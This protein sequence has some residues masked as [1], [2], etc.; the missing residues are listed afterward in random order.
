MVSAPKRWLVAS[1]IAAML[2]V[3][4]MGCADD[5]M[6]G[7]IRMFAG[8]FEPRGWA[9]CDGRLL[10]ISE[11]DTLF[12]LIGTTYGG[13]GQTTFALPDLRGRFPIGEGQGPG[14]STNINAGELSGQTTKTLMM[15]EMPA[16]T[17]TM[18]G[19]VTSTLQSTAHTHSVAVPNP[20][21]ATH[22]HTVNV[23]VPGLGAGSTGAVSASA[24]STAAK[25]GVSK[26]VRATLASCTTSLSMPS[27]TG[28]QQVDVS[29]T[30]ESV[31]SYQVTTSDAGGGT[32]TITKTGHNHGGASTSTGGGQAFEIRSPSL[33]INYI[34]SLYGVFPTYS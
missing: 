17:H 5:P 24:C 19:T 27:A 12:V 10:A 32:A 8:N 23:P 4:S 29:S 9:F 16:H 6:I 26:K 25:D 30:S 28:S 1:L 21:S 11:Y 2:T 3:P 34:I 31:P 13:D 20:S 22:N 15:T 33:G 7:E 14:L 18:D